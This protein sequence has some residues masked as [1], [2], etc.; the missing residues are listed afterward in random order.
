MSA[1]FLCPLGP[2]DAAAKRR[3][4]DISRRRRIEPRWHD[5]NMT[6][7]GLLGLYSESVM[8]LQ[9]YFRPSIGLSKNKTWY[10]SIL[11]LEKPSK[12]RTQNLVAKYLEEVL[13]ISQREVD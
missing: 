3:H 8:E 13:E 1:Q 7:T 5:V 6:A 12:V 9:G 10:G 4:A 2:L 11:G